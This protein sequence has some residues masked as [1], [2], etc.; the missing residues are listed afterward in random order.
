MGSLLSMDSLGKDNIFFHAFVNR[1]GGR[2]EPA[3]GVE[4]IRVLQ[5]GTVHM[6]RS[7]WISSQSLTTLKA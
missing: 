7:E 1:Q 4:S 3:E 5:I 2:P 6:S